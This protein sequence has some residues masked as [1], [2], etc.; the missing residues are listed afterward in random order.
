MISIKI[1]GSLL[2]NNK[3]SYFLKLVVQQKK[4]CVLIPGGGVFA[5]T[6]RQQ[7]QKLKFDDLTA[8]NLSVLSM[9]KVGHILKSKISKYCEII[10]NTSQLSHS[11]KCNVFIWN[12][13]QEIYNEKNIHTNWKMTSD[14]IALKVSK[15]I[16]SNV[17]IIVKSCEIPS[18]KTNLHPFVLN[19][20]KV[21]ELSKIKILD[22]AFPS[23][24]VECQFPVYVISINQSEFL[25]KILS[26][27]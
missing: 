23:A 4:K 15:K 18:D 10:K 27:F 9:L 5:D 1:G 11:K 3:L 24:Y 26:N 19:K 14:T 22:K 6:V 17:L 16:N 25:K 13:E 20:K 21:R 7:Q 8:H 12:P 2:D